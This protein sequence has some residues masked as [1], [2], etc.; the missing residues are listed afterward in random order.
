MF[1]SEAH[2]VLSCRTDNMSGNNY[3]CGKCDTCKNRLRNKALSVKTR[4][5]PKYRRES[6]ESCDDDSYITDHSDSSYSV[7]ES[8]EDTGRN[9]RCCHCGRKRNVSDDDSTSCDDEDDTGEES[10]NSEDCDDYEKRCYYCSRKRKASDDDDDSG[11]D[12]SSTD[13]CSDTDV[14]TESSDEECD[15]HCK[16][17]KSSRKY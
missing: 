7:E 12:E 16:S 15:C 9:Q 13:T 4:I 3:A 10:S 8:S 1:I 5:V 2:S 11:D 14:S 17:K 6:S